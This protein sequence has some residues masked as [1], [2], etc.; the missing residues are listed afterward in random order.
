MNGQFS[1]ALKYYQ[2]VE[3][4]EPDNKSVIYYTGCCFTELKQYDEALNCFFKL[5]FMEADNVKY[6]RAIAWCSFLCGKQEQ[7]K[8][9]YDKILNMQPNASDYL[10]AG[11]IAWTA[12]QLEQATTFY[13][14]AVM[15]YGSKD[16][17]LEIFQNDKAWLLSQGISAQDIPFVLDMI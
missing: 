13:G 14:K 15:A 7:A 11:H 2:Q 12:G 6:W 10:N 16:K 8:K 5:D 9:Y 1:K 3:S 17:F 4:I